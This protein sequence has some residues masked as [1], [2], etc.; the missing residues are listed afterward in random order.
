MTQ[1]TKHIR[2]D[3]KRF[4]VLTRL[5]F[6]RY[7]LE[8][9]GLAICGDEEVTIA[10]IEACQELRKIVLDGRELHDSKLIAKAFGSVSYHLTLMKAFYGSMDAA[11]LLL[12]HFLPHHIWQRQPTG[13]FNIF[14]ENACEVGY[15]I[16]MNGLSDISGRCFLSAILASMI[17]T[18][19]DC[20][21]ELLKR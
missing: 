20:H 18:N 2:V 8:F 19:E 12:E 21:H 16:G 9:G 15:E 3:E 10:R 5:G 17:K 14:D 4:D 6:S 13:C 11:E 7:E 1:P